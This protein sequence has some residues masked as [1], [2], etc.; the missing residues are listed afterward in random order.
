MNGLLTSLS[1]KII[2]ALALGL[3]ASLVGNFLLVRHMWIEAGERKGEAER[4]K[5]Q[6]QVETFERSQAVSQAL[7]KAGQEDHEDL[8]ADLQAIA[9]STKAHKARGGK[10][11]KANPLP[12]VCAPGEKRVESVNKTLGPQ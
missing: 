3:G 9:D 4:H 10:V 2:F 1:A 8:V 11:A 5:L 12:V 6:A 7:L